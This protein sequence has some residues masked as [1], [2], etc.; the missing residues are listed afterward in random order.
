MDGSTNRAEAERWLSIAERLLMTS[1]F[2][3]AKSFA[4]RARDSDP[5]TRMESADQI[6]AVADTLLA[7]E[8]R[9]PD[10]QPNW[11]AILQLV[12]PTQS[13]E[14][15]ATQFRRL[16]ILLSP[17][18]NRLVFA[19]QAFRLVAD[20]WSVLS[21]PAKKA[22]FDHALSIFL[23]SESTQ[24]HPSV[25]RSP[26]TKDGKVV[27][28]DEDR[29]SFNHVTE[30]AGQSR[31]PPE[32][33]GQS[34]PTPESTQQSR[35]TPEPTQQLRPTPEPTRQSRPTPEPTRQSRPTP[36]SS[37]Q[38]RPTPESTR[39]ETRP[40]E[41]ESP[42]FWTACPY[43]YVLYEYPKVYEECTLRCQKCKM[44]F[45]A[46][47]IPSPPV[48]DKDT[49]FC[50][51]GFFPLGLSCNARDS[52]GSSKWTP[53]SSVFAC[54]VQAAGGANRNVSK[55][56]SAPRVYY[57]DHDALLEVSDS[58]EDSDDEWGSNRRKRKAKKK[59]SASAYVKKAQNERV[60]RGQPNAAS[61]ETLEGSKAEASKKSGGGGAGKRGVAELGKL[62]LNVEFS[63][64]AEE[65]ARGINAGN[66][67]EDNIE[68]IG[69]FEGL[70]EFLSSLPILKG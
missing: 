21:H 39:Q 6:I 57:D 70:D 47:M 38:S 10:G 68:G 19:D 42:S 35:P 51:W 52:S 27:S 33:T 18:R 30:S 17:E 53:M 2:H 59:A 56:K 34:R 14:L 13:L 46:V 66:G 25:R 4:I 61:G 22:D 15:I 45:H 36:E 3:G 40:V 24:Q 65:P 54:P 23:A 50:C 7:G 55:P 8:S 44:A 9:I 16:A 5:R 1:D 62:D 67:E 26:R 37:R 12:Q 69:F 49:Y 29:P 28:A 48:T 20:A 11:Y 31:P 58:S 41:S 32:S 63:N 43:C 60:R 64:E